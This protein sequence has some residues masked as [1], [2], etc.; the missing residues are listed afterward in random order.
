MPRPLLTVFTSTVFADVARIWHACVT[1]AFPAGEVTLEMFY[2]SD[3]DFPRPDLFPGTTILRRS[4]QVREFHEAYND[5]VLRVQ[6]PYLAII[7]SDVFWVSTDLWAS[8]R[9]QLAE[10]GVAAISCVS[11]S[12]KESHG[13]FALVMNVAA[14]RKVFERLPAGF[15]PAAEAMD[16]AAPMNRWRWFDTGDLLTQ[17]VIEAGYKVPLHHMDEGGDVVQFRGITL[18]RMGGRYI[19]ARQLARL[20][21]QDRYF[22]RG[23][24]GNLLLKRLHD[25]LFVDGPRYDFPFNASSLLRQIPRGTPRE[26]AWRVL[27]TAGDLATARKV[28][29]FVRTNR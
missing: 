22:F 5:A 15:F 12:G 19:G 4:S 9:E 18:S 13:T 8:V 10:P 17:A 1:R 28:E 14:Y 21:G 26:I 24:V 2:D 25:R 20:G 23:Y 7:D 27:F 3:G 16:P 6:T 29:R 11:R